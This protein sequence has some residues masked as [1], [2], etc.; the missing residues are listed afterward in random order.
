ML[1][2]GLLSTPFNNCKVLDSENKRVK[3]PDKHQ[4]Q[5]ISADN[6]PEGQLFAVR[7]FK[8]CPPEE[9]VIN[10]KQVG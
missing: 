2:K 8:V 7:T 5:P 4:N 1:F 3:I 6:G 10:S 9:E